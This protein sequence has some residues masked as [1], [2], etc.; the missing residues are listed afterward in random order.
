[1]TPIKFTRYHT[2]MYLSEG[3]SN[4]TEIDFSKIDDIVDYAL[5][6]CDITTNRERTPIEDFV[7]FE[8]ISHYDFYIPLLSTNPFHDYDDL[9]VAKD[10]MRQFK[11]QINDQSDLFLESNPEF[12]KFTNTLREVLDAKSK[13]DKLSVLAKVIQKPREPLFTDNYS[14]VVDHKPMRIDFDRDSGECKDK[15][16]FRCPNITGVIVNNK[17]RVIYSS[18]IVIGEL[19]CEKVAQDI[20]VIVVE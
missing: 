16:T 13:F 9:E 3:T 18:D 5:K 17:N 12:S 6:L 19:L 8:I 4:P 1:M 11:N 15:S 20:S 2:D 10:L 7:L 14:A